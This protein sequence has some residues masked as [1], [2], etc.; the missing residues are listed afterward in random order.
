MSETH[1]DTPNDQANPELD[2]LMANMEKMND[3]LSGLMA[4]ALRM[5]MLI[6]EDTQNMIAEFGA[7]NAAAGARNA[8]KGDI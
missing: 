1:D 5:Q 3:G 6:L 2:E 7:M 4:S 8:N